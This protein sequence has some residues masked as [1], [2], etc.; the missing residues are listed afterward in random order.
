MQLFPHQIDCLKQTENQNRVGYFLDMG[1]GKTF[2]GSEKMIQLGSKVNLIVCQK[3]K[4]DDWIEHFVENYDKELMVFDCTKLKELELF[5]NADTSWSV[6]GVINYD[7]IW[8]RKELLNLRDFT[9]MLDE[10]S[11][12]QNTSA[13]RTKF[14]LKMQPA[15]VILLSGTPTGGKYENL[16]SQL[17][18]LGWDISEKV[19]DTHYVNYIKIEVGGDIHKVVNKEEPYKNVDRLKSKMREHGSV[20]LKTDEVMELPEQNIIEV[21]VSTSKEYKRFTKDR[22]VKFNGMELVGDSIFEYRLNQRMLCGAYSSEKIEAFRDLV[23]STNDRL[24]VFYNFNN[25]LSELLQVAYECNR[26]ISEVS[27]KLKD[28]L[29]YE[30]ES[31]AIIFVQYQAGSMGLN[32]QK[33]NKIIYFSLPESSELFEQSK[34]RIHRIG[35]NKPCFYYLMMCKDSIEDNEI[36]PTLNIRKEYTD[37]LFKEG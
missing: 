28:L 12:I 26:P 14:I 17:H 36:L 21:K 8:R 34:K 7:L 20:F 19:Y 1:L 35:Q 4:I 16:W 2:V 11:L 31:N 6:I 22:Y 33:A 18:L 13:K 25:E 15:N 9:L 30:T 10:S 5:I 24:V 29:A 37:E 23:E 32:L 27:G 3:S